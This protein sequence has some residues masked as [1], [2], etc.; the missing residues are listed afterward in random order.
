MKGNQCQEI[1]Q[2]EQIKCLQIAPITQIQKH[3]Q[4]L[5][6][7]AVFLF[8]TPNA[9]TAFLNVVACISVVAV[10]MAVFLLLLITCLLTFVTFCYFFFLFNDKVAHR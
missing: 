6:A 3:P 5:I 9:T 1:P 10:V 7:I 4:V 8:V 2:R